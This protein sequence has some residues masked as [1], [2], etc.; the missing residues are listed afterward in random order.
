[1]EVT[2]Y[3]FSTLSQI[4]HC[5]LLEFEIQWPCEID[6]GKNLLILCNPRKWIAP[7]WPLHAYLFAGIYKVEGMYVL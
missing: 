5:N 3:Q 1:M 4:V 6:S 2:I 7:L